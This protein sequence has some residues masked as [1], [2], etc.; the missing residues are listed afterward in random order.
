MILP[1]TI[2]RTLSLRRREFIALTL[3]FLVGLTTIICAIIRFAVI[4]E[5]YRHDESPEG[6]INDIS[7]I[8]VWSFIETY[9]AIITF[10]L[11]AFR[12]LL[13]HRRNRSPR[14]LPYYEQGMRGCGTLERS[15]LRR[16][17]QNKSKLSSVA[18]IARGDIGA[19]DLREHIDNYN[20]VNPEHGHMS[21]IGGVET[22]D[23]S[24]DHAMLPL[25]SYGRRIGD[26]V[27]ITPPY[28]PL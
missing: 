17:R 20:N 12:V 3:V 26:K 2:L 13:N 6:K 5:T 19:S 24:S 9:F 10:C 4:H 25:T 18:S 28:A 14:A 11:P 7:V 8:Q 16:C 15:H 21:E 1:I 27:C 23:F 22:R